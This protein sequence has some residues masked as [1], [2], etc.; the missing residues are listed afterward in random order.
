MYGL[1]SFD[2]LYVGSLAKLFPMYAAFELRLRVEAQA[3]NMI[4]QGLS[5]STPGWEQNVFTALRTAWQPQ[6]TAKFPG[7]P[8]GF[9]Q[10]GTIFSLSTSGDVSFRQHLPALTDADLDKIEHDSPDKLPDA[11]RLYFRDWMR[12]MLRWSNGAASSR[13][14]QALSYPYINGTLTDAGFFDP[15]LKAG[16]W[17]SGDYQGHDWLSANRAG[18]A[19][20]PRWAAAQG[21]SKSNFT[22]T[23]YHLAGFM[24]LLARGRLIDSQS[25]AD[26]RSILTATGGGIGSYVR[27]GLR[28][29]APPRQFKTI[30]NKIGLGDP[31]GF[32]HDAAIVYVGGPD[33]DMTLT[34]VLWPWVPLQPKAAPI[35]TSS[36]SSST[37]ASSQGTRHLARESAHRRGRRSISGRTSSRGSRKTSL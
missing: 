7:L 16:L 35:S 14:I 28:G 18:Q 13:C 33:P 4:A 3:Q 19:L 25:S 23:S 32:S 8:P 5:T 36:S 21:R 15:Q 31:D 12:L 2:M 29:A 22:A 27:E 6:L 1:N 24:T 17:L 37:T 34:Y 20:T 9:P 11:P 10:L 26:M 30:R